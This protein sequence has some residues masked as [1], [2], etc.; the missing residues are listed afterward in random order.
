M[1]TGCEKHRQFKIHQIQCQQQKPLLDE[2]LSCC[3]HYSHGC[4]VNAL[5]YV[6]NMQGRWLAAT[7]TAWFCGD[8]TPSGYL[9]SKHVLITHICLY[10]AH[11]MPS[12][13]TFVQSSR[14]IFHRSRTR[15]GLACMTSLVSLKWMFTHVTEYATR[16]GESCRAYVMRQP[17]LKCVPIIQRA[18]S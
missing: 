7:L 12:H 2:V 9:D 15:R 5:C 6:A 18:C 16:H 13:A 11:W 17:L 10:R 3:L 8:F 4:D 1:P 14:T